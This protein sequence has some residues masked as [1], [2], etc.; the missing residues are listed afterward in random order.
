[1]KPLQFVLFSLLL[2][3]FLST[4]W[5]VE[6][7]IRNRLNTLMVAINSQDET[8]IYEM[9]SPQLKKNLML[10]S[11]RV[12]LRDIYQNCGRITAFGSVEKK[13]EVYEYS[14]IFSK[15]NCRI[16]LSFDQ[17]DKIS[18]FIIQKTGP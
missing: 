9:I 4:A 15:S 11:F 12:L 18:Y 7:G 10:H 17:D 2:P 5:P 8:K 16:D 13:D 1:M 14:P 6:L 3:T